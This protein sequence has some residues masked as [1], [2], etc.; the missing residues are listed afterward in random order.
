[1]RAV[2]A[3]SGVAINVTFVKNTVT[4]LQTPLGK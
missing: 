3:G 1:M 2:S 4:V